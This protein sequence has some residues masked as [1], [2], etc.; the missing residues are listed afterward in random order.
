[1]ASTRQ[2]VA[3]ALDA[4]KT[5]YNIERYHRVF[6]T[7]AQTHLGRARELLLVRRQLLKGHG[8]RATYVANV[9]RFLAELHASLS[10]IVE[11]TSP[12]TLDIDAHQ[13]FVTII[14]RMAPSFMKRVLIAS[15]KALFDELSRLAMIA[16]ETI[17]AIGSNR[18][19]LG[20][21]TEGATNNGTGLFFKDIQVIV[22]HLRGLCPQKTISLYKGTVI[23]AF[24]H[25]PVG[26]TFDSALQ[27]ID[28][29]NKQS[30]LFDV[31]KVTMH[32]NLTHGIFN[33]CKV[34]NPAHDIAMQ[35]YF[36]DDLKE[37]CRGANQLFATYPQLL[38]TGV[39]YCGVRYAE[40]IF[41]HDSSAIS[42]TGVLEENIAVPLQAL[43]K[44]VLLVHPCDQIDL[45]FDE[46]MGQIPVFLRENQRRESSLVFRSCTSSFLKFSVMASKYVAR[47]L[48]RKESEAPESSQPQQSDSD[49]IEPEI[50]RSNSGASSHTLNQIFKRPIPILR[51]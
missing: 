4:D 15:N 39:S 22:E 13:R 46:Y 25:A 47:E 26:D 14:K 7:L 42:G 12:Y 6:S 34:A 23:D 32:Y 40:N 51:R 1:M 36:I 18:Q 21:D 3:I 43:A 35:Y 8:D 29:E 45:I 33:A 10:V 27:G 49:A 2:V 44:L 17:L 9:R 5:V 11:D 16:D 24:N 41:T 31:T 30:Y 48:K 50:M 37:L 19:S 38:P 20:L 28:K